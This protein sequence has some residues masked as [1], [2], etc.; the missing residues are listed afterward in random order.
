MKYL[1]FVLIITSSIH[2]ITTNLKKEEHI[3][4]FSEVTSKI[5]CICIPSLPIKSCS[6]NNCTPSADL[7]NFI[8]T[9]IK[10]GETA[11]HI[12]QGI[13]KGYGRSILQD[14]YIQRMLKS[15]KNGVVAGI[16]NGWG[17]EM[18]A[19]PDPTWINLSLIAFFVF[20]FTFIVIYLNRMKKKESLKKS[21]SSEVSKVQT[22]YLEELEKRQR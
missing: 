6:F 14:D 4:I 22:D 17:E 21:N 12:I 5:R 18:L 9:R 7:K 16:V 10:K 3:Q 20:G 2:S 13:I 1:F 11:E 19:E 15:G 8:E